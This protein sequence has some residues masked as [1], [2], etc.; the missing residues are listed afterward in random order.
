MQQSE[1]WCSVVNLGYSL[2]FKIEF[3][4]YFLFVLPKNSKRFCS[5]STGWVNFL[6]WVPH[7]FMALCDRSSIA[8]EDALLAHAGVH[9]V[10]ILSRQSTQI[11]NKQMTD[12]LTWP[13]CIMGLLVW[14]L[15]SEPSPPRLSEVHWNPERECLVR[16]LFYLPGQIPTPLNLWLIF[17]KNTTKGWGGMIEGRPL[18]CSLHSATESE[19]GFD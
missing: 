19:P 14:L 9:N 1:T 2:F 5:S 15:V 18:H 10:P 6:A 17:F 4:Q 16:N 13:M 12:V 3:V 8:P 7:Y 11:G